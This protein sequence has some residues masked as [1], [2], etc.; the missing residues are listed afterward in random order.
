MARQTHLGR[1]LE[2]D[3]PFTL[4]QLCEH[5]QVER[6][7][8]VELVEHGVLEPQGT[9]PAQW[10]FSAHAVVRGRR[11]RRL[12]QDFELDAAGVS[13]ALDLLEEVRYLRRRVRLLET[14]LGSGQRRT[15]RR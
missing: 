14:R 13:L 7:W 9:A 1:L 2:Q 10:Q 6:D 12:R 15:P 8:I 3:E 5:C 11:A 4:E